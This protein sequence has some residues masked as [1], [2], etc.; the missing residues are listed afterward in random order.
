MNRAKPICARVFI[1]PNT[2]ILVNKG[3]RVTRGQHIGAMGS[4]GRST[5]PHLH[6]AVRFQDRRLGDRKGYVNPEKFILDQARSDAEV[7]NWWGAGE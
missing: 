4:T 5:G 2:V 6:Y 7:S 1:A 3:Q